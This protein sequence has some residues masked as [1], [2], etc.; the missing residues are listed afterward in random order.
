M[1]KPQI[2]WSC[3]EI[4]LASALSD[5]LEVLDCCFA[6]N[7]MK[8]F[9]EQT[10]VWELMTATGKNRLT[11]SGDRAY[12]K[13]WIKAFERLYS[14]GQP[15]TTYDLNQEIHRDSGWASKSQLYQKL[16]AVITRHI[17]LAPP[18]AS[19]ASQPRRPDNISGYLDVRIAFENV[20]MLNPD[21]IQKLCGEL[22]KLPRATD[23]NVCD[24][25]YLGFTPCFDSSHYKNLVKLFRL[26]HVMAK[27]MT[28]WKTKKNTR[29]MQKRKA[30]FDGIFS[31]TREAKRRHTDP[32]TPTSPVDQLAK[33]LK[34]GSPL[35][36]RSRELSPSS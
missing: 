9:S 30:R 3:V 4:S 16:P 27:G 36:P 31:E 11:P 14:R 32:Y 29:L 13:A 26:S 35:T 7:V 22:C 20:S 15:F 25:Q 34:A 21:H 18:V 33:S 1:H 19:C 23:L 28:R 2:D 5:T 10:R 6:G 24:L 17:V 8:G 12:A